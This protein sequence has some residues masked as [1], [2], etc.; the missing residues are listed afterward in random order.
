MVLHRPV[1]L[2][3]FI[4]SWDYKKWKSLAKAG[5]RPTWEI[6][7][8][9]ATRHS[10]RARELLAIGK[11]NLAEMHHGFAVL[12]GIPDRGNFVAIL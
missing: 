5:R 11:D 3:P 4:G 1:E 2:A 7:Q 10:E 9:A 8:S 12:G 6:L